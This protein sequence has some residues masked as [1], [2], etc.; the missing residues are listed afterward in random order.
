LRIAIFGGAEDALVSH[1]QRVARD[2]GHE[3]VVLP[4]HGPAPAAFDGQSWFVQGEELGDCDGFVLRRYASPHAP[5]P[6]LGD[7]PSLDLEGWYRH[8][9]AQ[10]ERSAFSLSLVMAAELD[11]KPVVNPLLRC[12]PYDHK[13]LQLHALRAAGHAV[14]RTLVTSLPAAVAPFVEDV[15]EVVVKPTVGGAETRVFD[16]EFFARFAA[17]PDGP[18]VIFQERIHGPDIRATVVGERVVSCVE[19]VTD[20][21][22]YR[23][24]AAYREGRAQYREHDLPAAEAAACVSAA[25]VCGQVLSGVDLKRRP[26]GTYVLLE[27]NSAPM[28]LDIELKTGVPIT[29]AVVAYLE[30]RAG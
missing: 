5:P 8:S 7:E 10:Q 18:P 4:V 17:S 15:G 1:T 25:G 28:Y 29:E 12:L 14:P 27:C 20:A 19:I 9:L 30:Q 23:S 11:G 2:R 24:D 13:P 26:D 22:D 16:D 6:G 21:L 3:V